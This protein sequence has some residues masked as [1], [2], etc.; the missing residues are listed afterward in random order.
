MYVKKTLQFEQIQALQHHETQ[1]IWIRPGLKNV[2]KIYF[3]NIYR[4][5][6]TTQGNSIATQRKIL[7]KIL[8]QWE[9]A[10]VHN[11]I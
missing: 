10:V 8:S 5:H 2:K 9:A 1:T 7:D 6:T 3:A 4:E 11:N